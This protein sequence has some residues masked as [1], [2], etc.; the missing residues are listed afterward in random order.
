MLP[1]NNNACVLREVGIECLLQL[2]LSVWGKRWSS[3]VCINVC[4]RRWESSA[5]TIK[6]MYVDGE[7]GSRFLALNIT[8]CVRREVGTKFFH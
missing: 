5:C 6:Y 1:S 3:N 8:M 7:G 2:K 4:R